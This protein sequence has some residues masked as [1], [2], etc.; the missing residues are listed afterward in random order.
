MDVAAATLQ[1]L[2]AG[3]L[4]RASDG[5]ILEAR[6]SVTLICTEDHRIIVD[7]GLMDESEKITDSLSRAGLR[8][9][10]ISI[11]INT[12]PHPDHSG[13][14]HLFDRAAVL[15][16]RRGL[17]RQA[18][19]TP[20]VGNH[21]LDEDGEVQIDENVSL[22]LTPGHTPDCISVIIKKASS[23]FSDPLETIVIAGDALPTR[24]NFVRWVP[25]A[26]HFSST[27][28]LKSM[29]KITDLADWVIPGHD[30]PFRI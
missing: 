3:T 12:H 22:I 2:R 20:P 23:A 8:P 17:F 9:R 19:E 7:T 16:G 1:V 18:R 26:I 30:E 21:D 13:G 14:N 27:V 5:T 11:V 6:S 28:S 4:R 15:C 24:G 29:A 25:P 10:D